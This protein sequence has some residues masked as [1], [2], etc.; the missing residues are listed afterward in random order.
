MLNT[1]ASELGQR[2]RMMRERKG[3]SQKEL[4]ERIPG[5]KQQSI[6]QLEQGKIRRPRYLPELAEAFGVREEWLR[7]GEGR[8]APPVPETYRDGFPG[9]VRDAVLG[10]DRALAQQG[11]RVSAK[12]RASL[13]GAFFELV[14]SHEGSE[15]QQIADMADTIVRYEHLKQQ[16]KK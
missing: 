12:E 10:I 5:V 9:L 1:K 14:A 3:W 13:I 2:V 4:A 6:D 15:G 8:M 7:T 16:D 11:M